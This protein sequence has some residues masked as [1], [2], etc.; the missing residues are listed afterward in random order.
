VAIF[1]PCGFVGLARA[2]LR[3]YDNLSLAG[4]RE[5]EPSEIPYASL[6]KSPE[7]RRTNADD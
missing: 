5:D 1:T 4:L 2:L 7:D 6:G 3:L